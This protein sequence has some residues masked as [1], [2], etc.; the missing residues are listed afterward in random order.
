MGEEFKMIEIQKLKNILCDL[1]F[2][3][4]IVDRLKNKTKQK[5]QGEM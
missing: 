5:K 4:F 3:F 1:L 2:F